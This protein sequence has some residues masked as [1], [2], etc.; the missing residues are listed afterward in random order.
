MHPEASH[1]DGISL[2]QDIG[3]FLDTLHHITVDTGLET[4]HYTVPCTMHSGAE[5]YWKV[6]WEMSHLNPTNPHI[7]TICFCPCPTLLLS[8]PPSPGPALIVD[9]HCCQQKVFSQTALG[10]ANEQY[11]WGSVSSSDSVH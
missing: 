2:T 3:L 1:R 10:C 5:R 11:Y 9:S 8:A 6:G 7:N 4:L